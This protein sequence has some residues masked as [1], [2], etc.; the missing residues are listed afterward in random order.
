MR[1]S[2][3]GDIRQP[4]RGLGHR[5][6]IAKRRILKHMRRNEIVMAQS[7]VLFD[8]PNALQDMAEI[9]R[10]VFHIEHAL[11]KDRLAELR[12]KARFCYNLYTFSKQ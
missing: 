12:S 3:F 10:I 9:D 8:P 5:L 4:L 11:T 2:R 1:I 6:K 7:D